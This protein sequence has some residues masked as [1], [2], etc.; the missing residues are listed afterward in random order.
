MQLKTYFRIGVLLLVA[1]ILSTVQAA[2]ERLN[3]AQMAAAA[4]LYQQYC[5]LCPVTAGAM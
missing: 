1:G 5:T 2:D 4:E 3:A